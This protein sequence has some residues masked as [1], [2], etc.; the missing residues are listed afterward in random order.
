MKHFTLDRRT[1]EDLRR[2]FAALAAS[3]TP[4]WRL[5]N[6]QRDPGAA[7]AEILCHMLEQSIDRLN[8]VPD[9][10]FTDFLN[11]IGFRLPAPVSAAGILQ[12]SVHDTVTTPIRVPADTQVFTVDENGQNIVYET[13]RGIEAT[14][15]QLT[16]VFYADS[17]ADRLELFDFSGRFFVSSAENLQRHAFWFGQPDVLKLNCPSAI[18][19]EFRQDLRYQEEQTAALLAAMSWTYPHAGAMLPFDSVKAESGC[20]LLE[21]RNALS[22]DYTDDAPPF[23][24]CTAGKPT[25]ALTLEAIRL[26]SAPLERCPADMLFSGDL[27]LVPEEGGYC[28]GKRPAPYSLFYIRAD[29]ALSKR[30]ASVDCR[31]DI[32]AI[33]D[34]PSAQAP[35]Y[36][37]TQAIIDKQGAVE[38][39]PDDVWIS[40]VVW[41]YFNGLGWRRLAVSGDTNPFSCKREGPLETRFHV[42]DDMEETEVNA[43]S[44]IYIRV[45]VVDVTNQYSDYARWIVP[46]VREVSFRWQY[47]DFA[48]ADICGAENNGRRVEYRDAASITDLHLPALVPME[49][50][51]C[52]MYLRFDR[53]PHA[54]PLSMLFEIVG[55]DPFTEKLRWECCRN[56]RFETVSTADFTDNL[57]HTGQVL[58][59]L[60]EPLPRVNLFGREGH[61]L[62]VSRS[63]TF[64]GPA[65]R[66]S[67]IRL[68]TVTAKENQRETDLYFSVAP[69]DA[70]KTVS[71]LHTPVAQCE[72]WVDE[73]NAL[74]TAEAQALA[75]THTDTVR[76]EC[77][78]GTPVHCWVRWQ[79]VDDLVLA[80]PGARAFALDPYEGTIRFGNGRCGRVPAPGDRTIRVRYT[81][82]GGS[83]GNV[84]AGQITSF[85]GSLPRISVVRNITPMSGGN[86]RFPWARIEQIGNKRLRHRMRA[87]SVRDYEEIVLETFP[88]V[89]HIR[90][91][92]GRNEK[93]AAAPGHVTVV[94]M[95]ADDS[96]GTDALCRQIYDCLAGCCACCLPAEGRLHVRYAVSVTVNTETIVELESLDRAT[97]IQREM[98]RK[99]GE[100]IDGV[101]RSRQIGE[102]IRVN[103][104]WHTVRDIPGVRSIDRIQA[105]GAYDE[106]GQPRLIPLTPQT[107]FPYAVVRSGI[108]HVKVR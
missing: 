1:P 86:D 84:P 17:D 4:E 43:E 64:D 72:V 83:R 62:R 75:A 7:L 37:F 85:V 82:G 32:S 10:L 61:W 101:W 73:V 49:Q 45:R 21:K 30:G 87:A 47:S 2:I 34:A 25:L 11:L 91:F 8:A 66:V 16:H 97:E 52:A 41:E 88:Q 6:T 27:P 99:V 35:M 71:L 60:S 46:F 90:C 40:A 104:L 69:Y 74:S 89:V 48:A 38:R 14:S 42:P 36:N 105:E 93:G 9:K 65:P 19:V 77:E 13:E 44:G 24:L 53:S 28:F 18:E 54:M 79:K 31:L 67:A 107:N 106:N 56:G 23:I 12:F 51:P 58:L 108:H 55:R 5:E 33:V 22:I 68:N 15:A 78:N 3:Y 50:S 39:K 59:Y 81:S 98:I 70:D 20:L 76:L 26:R 63:S 94:V 96:N 95:G 80:P 29:N 103:E 102:Q 92:S 57:S 100:L